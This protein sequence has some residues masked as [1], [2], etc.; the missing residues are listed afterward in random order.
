[1][2]RRHGPADREDA[3]EADEAVE[4]AEA[5][6]EHID[7]EVVEDDEGEGAKRKCA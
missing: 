7:A 6:D 5:D 2:L 1:M 4:H 3:R